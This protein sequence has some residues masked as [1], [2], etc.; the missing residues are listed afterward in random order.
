MIRTDS[1][2]CCEVCRIDPATCRTEATD[3]SPSLLRCWDC[4]RETCG[5]AMPLDSPVPTRVNAPCMSDRF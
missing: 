1:P 4:A 5:G 3:A 2:R